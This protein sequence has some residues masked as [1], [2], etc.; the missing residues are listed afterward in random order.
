MTFSTAQDGG[1]AAHELGGAGRQAGRCGGS[2]PRM[3][4]GT[5]EL[6]DLVRSEASHAT[7]QPHLGWWSSCPGTSTLGGGQPPALPCL[8]WPLT[9]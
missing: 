3:A 5:R 7:P 4:K 1:G 2:T 9:K 8:F 6:K